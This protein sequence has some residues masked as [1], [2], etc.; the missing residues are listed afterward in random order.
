MSPTPTLPPAGDERREELRRREDALAEQAES[1]SAAGGAIDPKALAVENEL[2]EHFNELA[3]SKQDPAY[4]YK[5]EQA[6]F[7]GRFMKASLA[8]GWEVVQGDMEEAVELKGIGADTTRRLGDVILLRCR[9]DIYKRIKLQEEAHRKA[10]ESGVTT[11]LEELGARA[12]GLG[13]KVHNFDA[14]SPES[15]KR[16]FGRQMAMGQ[17]DRAIRSGQMPGVPIPGQR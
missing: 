16:M 3:V 8:R 17:V 10:V 13:V 1:A 7:Y 4:V 9:K 2:A 11:E 12:A 15:Q 6:G 5:W 14:M